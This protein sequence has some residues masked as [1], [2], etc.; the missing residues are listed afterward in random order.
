MKAVDD[1]SFGAGV[2][3]AQGPVLVD[4]WAEWCGPC[5]ALTPVIEALSAD[6]A[7]RLP[8]LKASIDEAPAA[9]TA[10]GIRAVPT[11]VLFRDGKPFA[12]LAGAKPKAAIIRWIE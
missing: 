4:F 3:Q 2:L 10:T 9:A 1:A 12:T 5:K 7:D 11:L 6:Y 8:F